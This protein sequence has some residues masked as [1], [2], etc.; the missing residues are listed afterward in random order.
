MEARRIISA[1]DL[2][3]C[4][5]TGCFKNRGNLCVGM[6]NIRY[7]PQDA[8]RF[9]EHRKALGCIDR[10]AM[11]EAYREVTGQEPPQTP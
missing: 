9:Y 6:R 5:V 11:D 8:R 7:S 4:P 3:S 2:P 1:D 10:P